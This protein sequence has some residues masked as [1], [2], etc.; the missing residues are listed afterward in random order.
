VHGEGREMKSEIENICYV[1]PVFTQYP[2]ITHYKP[3][4]ADCVK[5]ISNINYVFLTGGG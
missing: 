5:H 2:H 3:D 4:K 1:I